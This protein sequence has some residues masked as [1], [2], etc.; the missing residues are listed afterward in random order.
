MIHS[1]DIT[2]YLKEPG[3]SFMTR[4]HIWAQNSSSH[5]ALA[6]RIITWL[7]ILHSTTCRGGAMGLIS[8]EVVRRFP[9][10]NEH[11]PNVNPPDDPESDTSNHL[12]E[13]LSGPVF[14]F[15]FQLQILSG[16]I[17]RLSLYHRSR[18][19][20]TDQQEVV[21]RM[22]DLKSRLRALWESRCAT[23]RQSPKYLRSQLAPKTANMIINLISICEAA[24]LAEFIDIGRQLGDPVSK[25][26]DSSEALHRIREIV[27]SDRDDDD[28]T[29]NKERRINPAYLRPLFLYAIEGTDSERNRWAVEKIAQIQNPIYRGEFFSVFAKALSE[30]QIR[31]D[32]RVTSRYF[33]IWYF[34]V[35]PP[36]L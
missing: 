22:A 31:N 28:D 18:T 15:Y 11:L 36:F 5:S 2:P 20:G 29:Y 19:K 34:G 30:A 6:I 27:D 13:I 23:Q 25:S 4:I 8:D 7:K 9:D 32:R 3:T 16:E 1:G 17:A 26:T 12:Y 10:Y 14:N 35:T 24:Y 33:C 21:E